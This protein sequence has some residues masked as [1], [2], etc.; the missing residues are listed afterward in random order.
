[1]VLRVAFGVSNTGYLGL[2]TK[3]II[4]VAIPKKMRTRLNIR[5]RDAQHHINMLVWRG[6]GCR[7]TDGFPGLLMSRFSISAAELCCSMDGFDMASC[8]RET[9]VPC[10]LGGGVSVGCVDGERGGGGGRESIL[11]LSGMEEK[12]KRTYN[13]EEDGD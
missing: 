9:G 2:M 11:S 8:L 4:K 5:H 6:R 10:F 12:G 1:M 3:K 13:E 7:S